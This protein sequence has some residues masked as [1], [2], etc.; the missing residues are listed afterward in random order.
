LIFRKA[1]NFLDSKGKKMKDFAA[2][3]GAFAA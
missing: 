1:E 2:I 3:K